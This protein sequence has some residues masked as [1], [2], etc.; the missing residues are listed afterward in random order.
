MIMK[1]YGVI[2]YP[3]GLGN[4]IGVWG[5]KEDLTPVG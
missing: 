3:K 1:K 2:Y 5:R 4:R